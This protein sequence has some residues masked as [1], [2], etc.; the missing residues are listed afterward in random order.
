MVPQNI[1]MNC[2]LYTRREQAISMAIRTRPLPPTLTLS[3]GRLQLSHNAPNS[4]TWH[5][6]T[7]VKDEL[8][9]VKCPHL[10]A[11][12]TSTF[13]HFL[14]WLA[15]D[16]HPAAWSPT[17]FCS[18]HGPHNKSHFLYPCH[19][20]QEEAKVDNQRPLERESRTVE[21]LDSR[22]LV[23][24]R[25]WKQCYHMIFPEPSH[26]KVQN[27]LPFPSQEMINTHPAQ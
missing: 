20:T 26:W 5:F 18:L 17:A 25:V 15:W 6:W 9:N 2:P 8:R 13:E 11:W 4:H 27:E 19:L 21:L 7:C 24:P 10:V 22:A 16:S 1:R 3:R 23:G 14:R 12:I